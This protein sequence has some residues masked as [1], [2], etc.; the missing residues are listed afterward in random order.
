M[1]MPVKN[2]VYDAL[3]YAAQVEKAAKSH[4]KAEKERAKARKSGKDKDESF[5]GPS[6]KEYLS[7]FYRDDQLIPVITLVILFNPAPWD[8]PI[9]IHEMLSVKDEKFFLLC[10]IIKS[11]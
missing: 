6:S 10:R 1:A 11:T 8:G 3:Q 5:S 4:R 7:G 2:M 9:S